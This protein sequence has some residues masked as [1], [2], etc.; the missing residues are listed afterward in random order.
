MK[1]ELHI[2]RYRWPVILCSLVI[3]VMACLPLSRVKTNSDLI[4]YLPEDLASRVNDARI[5]ELFGSNEVLLI[6]LESDDVLAGTTLERIRDL[7]K[8]FDRLEQIDRIYSLYKA[9]SIKGEYGSMVVEPVYT[10]SPKSEEGRELLREEIRGNE[11][12]YGLLVSKDFRYSIILL[13][14][15]KG[16]GDVELM[17]RVSEVLESNPGEE[18]VS[19]FGMPYLR[20]EANARIARDLIILLPLGIV[21]ML[22]FLYLAF[23]QKR[24]ALL[25]FMAVVFAAVIAMSL[26]PMAGWEL[27][28]IGILIPIMMIAIANNYGVHFITRYQEMVA[29][30]PER[31]SKSLVRETWYYLRSPILLTGLTT[32]AGVSG[33]MAHVL[34]PARQMGVAAALGI[35][36]ALLFSLSF[37]P[38]VL[39][40][41][42]P[43]KVPANA[44]GNGANLP[45]RVLDTI[46]KAVTR[47]PVGV[48]LGFAVFLLLA[49]GGL[50]RFQLEANLNRLF[51]KSH[52]YVRTFEVASEHFGGTR[53]SALVFEGD[54]KDPEILEGMLRYQ[55]ELER[56]PEVGHVSSIASVIRIMSR[57]LNEPGDPLYDRIPDSREG[58]AQYLELYAMSGDAEDFESL[59]DFDYRHAILSLQF[60]ADGLRELREVDARLQKLVEGDPSLSFIGGSSY[61]DVDLAE[62]VAS[63]QVN[64]LLFAFIAI[65]LL[66]MLIFRSVLAGLLGSLPLVFTL[67]ATFGLM[68]WMNIQLNLVTALLSSISIGLG[69]DYSIHLFWRI[70]KEIRGGSSYREAVSISLRTIGRGISINAF[71][72]IL[73][74]CILLFSSFPYIRSF[75]ILIALSLLLCLAGALLLVPAIIVLKEPVFLRAGNKQFNKKTKIM[76]PMK[77]A[78]L[79]LS[80]LLGLPM[81]L[82]GQDA[83]ELIKRSLDAVE[84]DAI[85]M[86]ATLRTIDAKGRERVRETA[87]AT[88]EFEGTSKTLIRFIAPADVS[89]TTMLIHDHRDRDDD[90]WIY[91]PAL[92]KTR[93]IVSGE[94]GKSFMGSEF[95]NADMSR[96]GLDDFTYEISG[97]EELEGKHCWVVRSTCISEDIE[98]AMGYSSTLTWLDKKSYL[99]YRMEY[100]DLDGE[101]QKIRTIGEYEKQPD[102]TYMAR[103]MYMEN[104]RSGRSSVLRIDQLQAGSELPE[105]A[106]S[107]AMLE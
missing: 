19:M 23:R 54:M 106:F 12:A 102:G 11:L 47:R 90:M 29:S 82:H 100:Y 33:L 28:I 72:V 25:P 39:S 1:K 79:G 15:A 61:M 38:A 84:M 45:G 75:G 95:S 92:R 36:F 80:V 58:V 56:W 31:G 83:R 20:N 43:G 3:V 101:K 89:G 81:L 67:L 60:R 13:S 8:D 9:R 42:K 5:G 97:E 78:M 4:S 59:V 77:K 87:T 35:A 17:Q 48:I 85:E 73:G 49:L 51:P 55:E 2:I 74:F 70:R 68:G 53:N 65:F 86:T 41:L 30:H 66:L 44:E 16:I 14:P 94:K 27:S 62:A 98:D 10:R 32:M 37:I 50:A 63:G 105:S 57:A 99:S 22:L 91:M 103:S 24:G 69:V 52:P 96:P 46:A 104:I 7:S 21:L 88:R 93:R 76:R 64:S 71:S 18:K 40:L 26:I 6:L 34:L 107:P